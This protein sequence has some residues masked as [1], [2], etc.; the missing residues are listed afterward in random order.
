[1][2]HTSFS[3]DWSSDVCS[4][5]LTVLRVESAAAGRTVVFRTGAGPEQRVVV[6]AILVAAGRRPNI[7]GLGLERIGV[8]AGPEGIEVSPRLEIGRA[9][10]RERGRTA[11][12]GGG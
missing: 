12:A 9:P 8:R 10:C 2:R 7:E 11:A 6:E 4:S 1:R 3:R 5:D